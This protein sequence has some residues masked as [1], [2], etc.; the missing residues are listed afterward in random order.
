MAPCS[1]SGTARDRCISRD[2]Y[3]LCLADEPNVED[4]TAVQ[5]LEALVGCV[6][7]RDGTGHVN[8]TL[9]A[10]AMALANSRWRGWLN[11]RLLSTLTCAPPNERVAIIKVLAAIGEPVGLR[12]IRE[13]LK[14]EY[15]AVR[16][17]CLAALARRECN[18]WYDQILLS[19]NFGQPSWAVGFMPDNTFTVVDAIDPEDPIDETV[20]DWAAMEVS[21]PKDE[22]R[23]RYERLANQFGL[24]LAWTAESTAPREET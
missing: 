4:D 10:A 20:V 16:R 13:W 17:V 22:I 8:S 6:D 23:Q 7:Q 12:A 1:S 24:K 2:A 3:A 18:D 14:H 21:L 19:E 9:D 15:P 11:E 5:V